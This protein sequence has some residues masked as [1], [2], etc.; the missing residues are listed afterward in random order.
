MNRNKPLH[1][2]CNTN[3]K[4]NSF[5]TI[6]DL[7][8]REIERQ[9][10][11]R[12]EFYANL[13]TLFHFKIKIIKINN[14]FLFCLCDT[15]FICLIWKQNLVS[16]VYVRRSFY[17]SFTRRILLP[18]L[19]YFCDK[20]RDFELPTHSFIQ[21]TKECVGISKYLS[22]TFPL[23]FVL[24]PSSLN[25]DI[26]Y[27]DIFFQLRLAR[28]TPTKFKKHTKSFRNK[29]NRLNQLWKK[30]FR[31]VQSFG[32]INS[33]SFRYK[34]A[35]FFFECDKIKEQESLSLE[36]TSIL[37]TFTSLTKLNIRNYKKN[38]I[39]APFIEA[40]NTQKKSIHGHTH[41][42]TS[43]YISSAFLKHSQLYNN[44]DLML[45]IVTKRTERPTTQ[46]IYFFEGRLRN[47]TI[48]NRSKM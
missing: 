22:H 37:Q 34:V 14:F 2:T 47:Q 26:K 12:K 31:Y 30:L 21:I 32:N 15:E 6:F 43:H 20:V 1:I 11:R 4:L 17:V 46:C 16:L 40:L 13:N 38:M 48:F 29:M 45:C 23:L 7:T 36:I 24:N 27:W 5:I 8:E 35:C 18:N 9:R 10:Q 28:M 42:R 3:L 19:F 25:K 33:S 41:I 44:V 39:N